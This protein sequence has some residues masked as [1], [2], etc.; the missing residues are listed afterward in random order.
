MRRSQQEKAEKGLVVGMEVGRALPQLAP[1]PAVDTEVSSAGAGAG[2]GAGW[3]PE[4]RPAQR[5]QCGPAG[6]LAFSPGNQLWIS[7]LPTWK[8]M[9]RVAKTP[10]SS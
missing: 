8:I 9:N 5:K 10:G 4:S 1:A 7:N 2:G 3:V 6:P